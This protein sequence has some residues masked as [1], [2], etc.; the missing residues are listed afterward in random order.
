MYFRGLLSNSR[1]Y[2]H[3]AA[4]TFQFFLDIRNK[5]QEILAVR[6]NQLSKLGLLNPVAPKETTALPRAVGQDVDVG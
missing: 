6:A 2:G 1:H 5:L 3:G 4:F